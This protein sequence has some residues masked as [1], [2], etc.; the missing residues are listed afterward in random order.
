MSLPFFFYYSTL[1]V[2]GV[3]SRLKEYKKQKTKQKEKK[4][5]F[6]TNTVLFF[7]TFPAF[8]T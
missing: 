6:S 8:T 4:T 1:N 2:L 5:A 3:E 7:Y